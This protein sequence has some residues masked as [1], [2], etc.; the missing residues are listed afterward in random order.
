M[1]DSQGII[2]VT[3]HDSHITALYHHSLVYP[4]SLVLLLNTNL[5]EFGDLLHFLSKLFC[6]KITQQDLC[7]YLASRHC[8]ELIIL[9]MDARSA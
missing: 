8:G 1:Y 3:T 4:Y 7:K 9:I 2:I 5:P 6:P